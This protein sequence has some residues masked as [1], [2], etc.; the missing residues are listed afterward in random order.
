MIAD[1][2]TENGLNPEFPHPDLLLLGDKP[3]KDPLAAP[4]SG[5]DQ[6]GARFVDAFVRSTPIQ[7]IVTD[8]I[9]LRRLRHTGDGPGGSV[10]LN[11]D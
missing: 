4:V 11:K 9:A 3:P 2:F 5:M 7:G 6:A 8:D 1:G 10:F